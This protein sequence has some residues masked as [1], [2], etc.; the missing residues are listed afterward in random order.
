MS[1]DTHFRAGAQDSKLHAGGRGAHHP[2]PI[3][4]ASFTIW[5]YAPAMTSDTVTPKLPE[6]P[7]SRASKGKREAPL[8]DGSNGSDSAETAASTG[9][10]AVEES[11]ESKPV[12]TRYVILVHQITSGPLGIIGYDLFRELRDLLDSEIPSPRD[13]TEIDLWLESP[14]GDAH[15][16]YKIALLLRSRARKLRVVIPDYAK[17]AATLLSL[18]ADEIYMAEAAELGPLDAQIGYEK[19]G[20]TI[21]ALDVARSLEDLAQQAMSISLAGGAAVLDTTRL[22]RAESLSAMV[23]FAT[24]LMAPVIS[25]LDPTMIHWSSSLL[26]VSVGY[27]ERLLAM[28]EGG[29]GKVSA[30][31]QRLPQALV[32]LYPTHGFVI[33]RDEA[34]SLGLPVVD[35]EHYEYSEIVIQLAKVLGEEGINLVKRLDPDQPITADSEE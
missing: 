14:G 11:E 29:P 19:E 22:S 27:A 8:T 1:S 20:M 21:S 32:E 25:K 15:A 9:E 17:S 3:R 24:K 18:A 6:L 13:E 35:L 2:E 5:Y 28:R 31:L 7:S 4:Y 34:R 23:D 30:K 26:N 16:A 10:A 33:S 12:S